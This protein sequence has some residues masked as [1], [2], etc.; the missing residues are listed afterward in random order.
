MIIEDLAS[1]QRVA[2]CTCTAAEIFDG[3]TFPE[4][5]AGYARE[6]GNPL[7]GSVAPSRDYYEALESTGFAQCFGAYLGSRMCGFGVTLA[8]VLPHYGRASATVESLFVLREA[9]AQGLGRLLM[10][11]IENHCRRIGCAAV[12][13]SAPVGSRFAQQLF[14][15]S[16]HYTNTNHIFCRKLR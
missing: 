13:Y 5:S 3:P 2:A 6:C 8:A 15:D 1:D 10:T 4:L 11:A 12:L 14:L 16:E 7:L 9:R